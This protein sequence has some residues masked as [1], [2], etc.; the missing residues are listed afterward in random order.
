[1]L[2]L[3]A[4]LNCEQSSALTA[5]S[6]SASQSHTGIFFSETCVSES[7]QTQQRVPAAANRKEAHGV[8]LVLDLGLESIGLLGPKQVGLP[9]GLGLLGPNQIGLLLGLGLLG[10]NKIG[11]LLGL[12]LLGP[13]EIGLLLGLG[14][15]GPA[16]GAPL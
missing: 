9:L 2:V 7:H 11:L 12:G 13:N 4:L 10:P 5:K 16:A 1:L 14:L 3:A 15:L 6:A 8:H